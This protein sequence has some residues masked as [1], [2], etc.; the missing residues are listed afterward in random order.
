VSLFYGELET[1]GILIYSNAGHNPPFVLRRSNRI[2]HLKNGGPVLG[3]NPDATYTRGFV[4][5]D[6]GD[7]LCMY[8]DGVVEAHNRRDEEFG[9]ERL[10]RNVKAHRDRGLAAEQIGR[11]V[12]DR[13]GKW[14]R[15]GEDDRTV[16]IVRAIET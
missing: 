5:L 6:P 14:G 2:E 7:I 13:V 16:V 11:E 1:G 3:P 4:K 10:M 12:L 9:M 8:S 15:K